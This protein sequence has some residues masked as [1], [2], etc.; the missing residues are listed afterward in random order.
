MSIIRCLAKLVLQNVLQSIANT[1]PV[2]SK[3][4]WTIVHFSRGSQI[5]SHILIKKTCCH[6]PLSAKALQFL[7]WVLWLKFDSCVMFAAWGS[8]SPLSRLP[9]KLDPSWTSTSIAHFAIL[10]RAS[11]LQWIGRPHKGL[12]HAVSAMTT[13]PPRSASSARKS[14][15]IPSG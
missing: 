1:V 9:R 8:G 5:Q 7:Q 10:P 15:S 12:C 4:K 14:M 2:L 13:L 11:V 6:H 3:H